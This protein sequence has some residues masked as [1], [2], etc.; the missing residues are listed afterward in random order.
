MRKAC[1]CA[2]MVK[3]ATYA[4][5][6]RI[7]K[8]S[9]PTRQ[10][11]KAGCSKQAPRAFENDK[12]GQIRFAHFMAHKPSPSGEAAPERHNA[13][14]CSTKAANAGIGKI[15]IGQTGIAADK[16]YG[17]RYLSEVV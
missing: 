4:T 2:L 17:T 16:L 10:T 9:K 6:H 5:R 11:N 14:K 1:R 15:A 12:N 3:K 8:V 13:I 7:G